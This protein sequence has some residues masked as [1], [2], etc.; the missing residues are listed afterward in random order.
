MIRL[1]DLEGA[2]ER[3]PSII[4]GWEETRAIVEIWISHDEAEEVAR[5]LRDLNIYLNLRAEDDSLEILE[6][7]ISALEHIRHKNRLTLAN[8]L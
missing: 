5:H 7:L 2:A 4:R 3:L 8:L 1:E 6:S